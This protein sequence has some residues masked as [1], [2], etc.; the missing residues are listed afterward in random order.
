MTLWYSRVDRIQLSQNNGWSFCWHLLSPLLQPNNIS[1]FVGKCMKAKTLSEN[2]QGFDEW[3][4]R[5]VSTRVWCQT[6]RAVEWW[7]GLECFAQNGA[8]NKGLPNQGVTLTNVNCCACI[9]FISS[10]LHALFLSA[11]CCM[12]CSYQ[13]AVHEG[14]DGSNFAWLL[15]RTLK[16]LPWGNTDQHTACWHVFGDPSS[17]LAF[18]LQAIIWLSSVCIFSLLLESWC[19]KAVD[20]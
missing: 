4:S 5:S 1:N 10:M 6:C 2:N 14:D 7:N 20:M 19:V 3:G 16:L 18:A 11:P 9:V 17:S 15:K 8:C 12:H 13:H